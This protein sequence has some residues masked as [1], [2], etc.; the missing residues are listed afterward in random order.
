MAP[1]LLSSDKV[2]NDLEGFA[3]K[4]SLSTDTKGGSAILIHNKK[5]T[6]QSPAFSS[7]LVSDVKFDGLSSSFSAPL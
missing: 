3:W 1:A 2:A 7:W 6:L 5:G 4:K